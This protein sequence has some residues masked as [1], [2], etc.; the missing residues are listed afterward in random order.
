MEGRGG[1]G[2]IFTQV[3]EKLGRLYNTCAIRVPEEEKDIDKE[4]ISDRI[5]TT[6]FPNLVL[7]NTQSKKL[8][9][10]KEK[11]PQLYLETATFISPSLTAQVEKNQKG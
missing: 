11:N 2:A 8:K 5:M 7:Q 9:K 10:E 6:N 3:K 4:K 1:G